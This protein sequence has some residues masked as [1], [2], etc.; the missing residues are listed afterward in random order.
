M[1]WATPT[2]GAPVSAEEQRHRPSVNPLEAIRWGWRMAE[3]LRHLPDAIAQWRE[4]V[5]LFLASARRM[6]AA[7]ASAEQLLAQVEASRLPE[8]VQRL[9][10]LS[11]EL[12]RQAAGGSAA[13]SEQMVSETQRNV[14]ALTR[15]LMGAPP[16]E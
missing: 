10:A 13:L 15:M 9:Q 8:Q 6:E 7:T 12:G 16:Q 11:M 2:M 5:E 1:S 14:E 3:E 4:G